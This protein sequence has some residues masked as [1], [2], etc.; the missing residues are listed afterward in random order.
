MFLISQFKKVKKKKKK[1]KTFSFLSLKYWINFFLL[2]RLMLII[3]NMLF[4]NWQLCKSHLKHILDNKALYL[5]EHCITLFFYLVYFLSYVTKTLGSTT[6]TVCYEFPAVI[7]F[8]LTEASW[9]QPTSVCV[10]LR[11]LKVEM[12]DQ[13]TYFQPFIHAC[14]ISFIQQI[15][16]GTCYMSETALNTGDTKQKN[17][18]CSWRLHSSDVEFLS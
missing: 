12:G 13:V 3:I 14:I 1:R 2:Y 8:L 18:L 9:S 15:F 5:K 10:R 16:I 7:I 6:L 17:S 4:I 11:V